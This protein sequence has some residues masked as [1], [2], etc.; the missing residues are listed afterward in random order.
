MILF[1]VKF[2]SAVSSYSSAGGAAPEE[3]EFTV[4]N[5]LSYSSSVQV[6]E[7]LGPQTP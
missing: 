5:A 7:G 1:F 6:C 2:C 3:V 4:I